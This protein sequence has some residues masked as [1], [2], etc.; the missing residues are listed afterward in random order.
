MTVSWT[1]VLTASTWAASPGSWQC[2]VSSLTLLP[3]D[4]IV[5][6]Q[7]VRPYAGLDGAR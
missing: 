2:Q 5:R 4:P 1:D 3:G 6:V 7:L